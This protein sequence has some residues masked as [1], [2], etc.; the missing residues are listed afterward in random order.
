[1][2]NRASSIGARFELW[3]TGWYIFL[4]N[5]LQGIGGFK[6]AAQA[7]S[8]RYQVNETVYRFKYVH[9]QYIA[10]LA[11]QGVPGLIL[12]LSVICLPVYIAMSQKTFERESEVP[13]FSI[14][15]VCMT[16]IVGCFAEDHFETKPAT[17]FISVLLALLLA[18]ISTGKLQ[19]NS[20]RHP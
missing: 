10:A 5:P 17:I 4:E 9:N 19:Q 11:T 7:N 1:M 6:T 2:Y 8:E 13:H 18:G 3:K 20:D 15:F 14:I 16:Y 12:F